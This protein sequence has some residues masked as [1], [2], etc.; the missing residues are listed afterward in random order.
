MFAIRL[1]GEAVDPLCMTVQH[2]GFGAFRPVAA[3]IPEHDFVARAR[4]EIAAVVAPTHE[5]ELAVIAAHLRILSSGAIPEVQRTVGHSTCEISSIAAEV[6]RETGRRPL[7]AP[8]F[9]ARFVDAM[10]GKLAVQ[11]NPEIGS[12]PVECERHRSA[13]SRCKRVNLVTERR[14]QGHH[15]SRSARQQFAIWRE[16][17]RLSGRGRGPPALDFLAHGAVPE[18]HGPILAGSREH[19]G[20][21]PPCDT[22]RA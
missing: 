7:V 14:P 15:F 2:D 5:L 16:T 19:G 20:A 17:Q 12:G 1:P 11:R 21:R 22:Q 18:R 4:G 8:R 9:K 13:G 10:H 6:Y 3:E